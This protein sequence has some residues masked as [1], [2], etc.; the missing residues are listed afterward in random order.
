MPHEEIVRFYD[1]TFA[2]QAL[3][4]TLLSATDLSAFKSLVLAEA[5]KRGFNFSQAELD[6]SFD[7]MGERDTFTGVDFGSAW[8]SRI[9]RYGW[10]PTGYSRT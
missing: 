6:A 3:Q 9:M 10:V 2:D 8:I 7:G 4:D 5:Q 1:A